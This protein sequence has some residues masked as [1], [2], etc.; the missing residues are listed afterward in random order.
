VLQ[1]AGIKLTSVASKTLGVS[2]RLLL[3]A[4]VA[5]THDPDILAELGRGKLRAKL[6]AL[7]EALDANFR[8]K[9]HPA[10]SSRRSSPT[11]TISTRR[12]PPSPSGSS[13]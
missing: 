8:S 11:S 3:E 12:S 1:D 4:L 7:R 10:C 13:K 5:G 6:P 9:H 2:V